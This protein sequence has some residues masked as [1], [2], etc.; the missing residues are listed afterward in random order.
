MVESIEETVNDKDSIAAIDPDKLDVY[1]TSNPD[2]IRS[3]IGSNSYPNIYFVI[4]DG[5]MSLEHASDIG[6]VEQEKE[7]LRLKK[8]GLT[9]IE[10]SVSSHNHTYLT[11]ASIFQLS[12]SHKPM[13]KPYVDRTPFYPFMMHAEAYKVPSEPSLPLLHALEK[14]DVQLI[15]QGNS[16][17]RSE[18]ISSSKWK[19]ASE[20]SKKSNRIKVM[21]TEYMNTVMPFHLPSIGGRFVV[22]IGPGGKGWDISGKQTLIPFMNLLGNIVNPAQSILAF[23]HHIAPHAPFNRTEACDPISKPFADDF[24]GY[25]ANYRCVLQ[26]IEQ[27]LVKIN[28]VDPD[29]IV[30]IQADHGWDHL[31]PIKLSE[32]KKIAYRAKIFNAIKAPETCFKSYGRP[33]STINSI[34]FALNCAYGFKF[35]FEDQ[36]H[37]RGFGEEDSKYGT[38]EMYDGSR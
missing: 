38:V 1:T 31:N 34:R 3:G 18:C 10:K 5:M 6:I 33:L 9:Y 27:F 15:W 32:E 17:G 28:T 13:S 22:E 16:W 36:I 37:Y 4:V 21:L 11:L 30:L 19:C 2:A 12:Y 35:P 26:E 20:V 29:S 24:S 7:E 8:L 23:V 14:V 25:R